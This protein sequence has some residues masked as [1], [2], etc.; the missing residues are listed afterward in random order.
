M[1]SKDNY[2][3]IMGGGIGSRFW[4]F[5]RKTMPKQFL[6][7]FGTGRSLLQQTFDRFNKIIPTENIL[8][9]TNAIY[10]DLVKEQLP[11]LDSKQILL[12]PAR[13]NTAPCIAWASYH[14]RSLNPDANIV[15]APSDHLILKEGEFLAAI[16]KGLDFVSKS[17]KLLTLGI[18]PNRPETGYGYIQIAEQ[19][20]DNFYKVKTFTEKPELELAKV[21]VESG[22]FYWNSGLFMWNVNTIIKAGEALLPELAS[23]LAPGKD[24]YGT[25]EEKAFIEENF[26]ACPNVSI[27]F[28]IMEKADNVYVSLGDFGWSDLGTWGSL[29]DLSPKDEQGNVT[30]KC[31]SMIYNSNNNIVVLPKG[32]LAVIEGL[33]GFLV[34]ESDN[35]L[36]ICKKDEEHAIRKY[37]NDAQMKLGEDYI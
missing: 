6:D 12:E 3:V 14:I 2:C 4:P 31:D 7:F 26:P 30:L 20:G 32:K 1:T 37:V 11:E 5:S 27:D 33:E 13:R 18:K 17:D 15:V 21:F 24:V 22:E 9:V 10:A 34:A 19:E 36:L 29:Y 16:E 8:I 28:G 35:V 25:P 23:K